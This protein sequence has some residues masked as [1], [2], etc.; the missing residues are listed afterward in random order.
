MKRPEQIEREEEARRERLNRALQM[1]HAE[2]ASLSQLGAAGEEPQAPP[3]GARQPPQQLPRRRQQRSRS[4]VPQAER[5]QQPVRAAPQGSAA[6]SP[7]RAAV[8]KKF[9]NCHGVLEGVEYDSYMKPRL[10]VVAAALFDA[11]R[12]RADRASVRRA[13]TWPAGGN[14]PGGKVASGESDGTRWCASCAKNSVSRRAPDAQLMTLHARV[15]RPA[16]STSCCGARRLRA[17]SRMGSMA[18]SL[19]WVECRS[20]GDERILEADQPFIEALQLVSS[21]TL[22]E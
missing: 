6:T 2:A 18:S 5:P 14:F 11:R 15:S 21:T 17:A 20:L 9:K 13:S 7:A 1:Q 4:A 19:K 22:T 10:R 3:P 12:P 8:G 16:S